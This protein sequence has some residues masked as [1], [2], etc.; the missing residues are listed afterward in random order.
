MVAGKKAVGIIGLGS[1][2]A[3][4]YKP[5]LLN[6]SE[7]FQIRVV[8]D[9]VQERALSEARL[10][11][12]ASAAGPTELLTRDDVDAGLQRA[13]AGD[14]GEVGHA[15]DDDALKAACADRGKDVRALRT[16]LPE[17]G[18]RNAEVFDGQPRLLGEAVGRQVIGVTARRRLA[19]L[20]QPFLTHRLR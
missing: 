19:D 20:D 14:L 18:E 4:H 10:L 6:L 8:C 17:E 5:A 16:G 2:W 12:C 13:Y 9:H 1:R 15:R 11:G 3:K 7:R